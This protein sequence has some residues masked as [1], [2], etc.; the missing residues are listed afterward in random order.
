MK[1]MLDF[2]DI[3]KTSDPLPLPHGRRAW[4][5][6]QRTQQKRGFL[7]HEEQGQG[8][9]LASLFRPSPLGTDIFGQ[10]K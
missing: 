5:H 8:T 9:P 7:A 4:Q 3:L 1:I 2:F 6:S 10:D